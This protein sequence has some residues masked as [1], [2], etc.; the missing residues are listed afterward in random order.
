MKGGVEIFLSSSKKR[1]G[2]KY[3]F[4]NIDK[5]YVNSHSKVTIICNDCGNTF[6][7]TA[8]DHITSVNGGCRFCAKKERKQ[9]FTYEELQKL[10]KQN[11]KSFNGE[12]DK[13]DLVICICQNHGEYKVKVDKLVKGAGFCKCCNNKDNEEDKKRKLEYAKQKLFEIYGDKFTIDFTN[14]KNLTSKIKFICNDCGYEFYRMVSPAINRRIKGCQKCH[15]KKHSLNMMK[16]TDEYVNEAKELYGDKYD[17]SKVVYTGSANKILVKCNECGNEFEIEANS[18]LQGHGCP[19][20]YTNKSHA[21]DEILEFIK[22][23]YSG[24]VLTHCRNVLR[25]HNELDIYIP[26]KQIAIEYDGVFW[27]N[28]L[29]KPMNYHLDKTNQCKDKDIH[30]IHIF[31]DE[32]NDSIKRGIW[33]SM[34]RNQLGLITNKIFARKCEIRA[35]DVRDGYRFLDRNHIQGKCSSTIMLGLYYNDVLVSLMTFGKSRHFI[36]NGKAEYELLRFCNRINTNV[37]GGASKL[38]SFF[39]RTY[40]PNSI[41]SYADKRWSKGNLYDKLGFTKYNESK[42]NYYYVIEGRRKNRFNYRKSVLIKKYG[43]PS[44]MSEREFCFN[45]KWY[46][47]YDCGCLC[48][49]WKNNGGDS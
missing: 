18:H 24:K 28:E 3:S 30:L 9:Y 39:L 31:E 8:A 43:C 45:Q 10:T 7:K 37:I 44:N 5:E 38:F 26:G 4:P 2:E 21:E 14:F 16:S 27:H 11:V 25:K 15:N 32:W 36:G 1:F 13:N 12:V 20:H 29:N 46:R 22:S 33:E 17:Y 42:P 47:I 40:K 6:K 19:Y 35:V 49:I 48:Y 34:M 23:I 41:V